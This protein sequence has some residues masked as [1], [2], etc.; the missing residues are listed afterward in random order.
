MKLAT[1]QPG[2]GLFGAHAIPR[3]G[4][5]CR[6][7][8]K[9]TE[10]PGETETLAPRARVRWSDRSEAVVFLSDLVEVVEPDLFSEVT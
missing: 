4:E 3:A 7:L 10:A 8:S 6:V 1:Y 2:G 9:D 5:R